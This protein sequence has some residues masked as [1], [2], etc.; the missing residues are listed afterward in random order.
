MNKPRIKTTVV[1]SYT[2]RGWMPGHPSMQE[3][4]DASQ[5]VITRLEQLGLDLVCD[6][7]LYRFDIAHPETNGMIDYFIGPMSGIRSKLNADELDE[8]L[9]QEGMQFRKAPP[10]IVDGAI[11]SG[12]IDLVNACKKLTDTATKPAKFTMTGPHMLAKTVAN[13]FYAS[14][15]EMAMAFAS[16][17]AEQA[18]QLSAAVIQIDEANL[19]GHPDEWEWALAAINMVLDSVKSTGAVHLCFGNYAGRRVQTGTW[20]KLLRYFDG[21]HAD[22]IVLECKNRPK[23]EVNVLKDIRPELGLGI[24]VIDI[25]STAVETADEVAKDLDR[26]ESILGND[27]IKYIHPDCGFWMLDRTIVDAKIN[28]LVKGRDMY[29]G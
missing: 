10:G 23:D 25:K 17:L 26:L 28:A 13:K 12:S 3:L 1:G 9:A 6:G 22:H 18:E 11:G 7:E 16:V 8:Y 14:T 27:R 15:E 20:D 5:E 2:I 19:P 29:L 4:K 21:L 24:G